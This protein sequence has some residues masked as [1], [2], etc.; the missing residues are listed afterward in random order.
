VRFALP[1]AMKISARF[2][3][4][5]GLVFAI[6]AAS[7]ATFGLASIHPEMTAAQVD[8]AKGFAMFFYFLGAIGAAMAWVSHLMLK[9]RF[10]SLDS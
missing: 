4:Y 6:L 10:G 2:S 9:G 1:T 3:F 8:D 5:L 7:Y